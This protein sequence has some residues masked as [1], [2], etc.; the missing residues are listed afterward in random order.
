MVCIDVAIVEAVVEIDAGQTE[1]RAVI[2]QPRQRRRIC[3][4]APR[5]LIIQVGHQDVGRLRSQSLVHS[6]QRR[7]GLPDAALFGRHQVECVAGQAGYETRDDAHLARLLGQ[8]LL[9]DDHQGCRQYDAR[10]NGLLRPG[11]R[12][13][14]GEYAEDKRCNHERFR[15]ARTD[16][17]QVRKHFGHDKTDEQRK[18][19]NP[20]VCCVVEAIEH[21]SAHRQKQYDNQSY[22]APFQQPVLFALREQQYAGKERQTAKSNVAVASHARRA[23][24][25]RDSRKVEIRRIQCRH[26]DA[27]LDKALV[28]EEA[29]ERRSE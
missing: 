25:T 22:E 11:L 18:R 24:K 19:P 23:H 4:V 13:E 2:T 27:A 12:H 3:V 17:K 14:D 21:A 20:A 9:D 16:R 15:L 10:G 29:D 6:S 8:A 7:R 28:T 5:P 1:N 26:R